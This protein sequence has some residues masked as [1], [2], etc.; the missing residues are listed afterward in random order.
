MELTITE[1]LLL[2]GILPQ[3]GNFVTLKIVRKLKEALSFTEEEIARFKLKVDD[4]EGT[5]KWDKTADVPT[6]IAIGESA[7]STIV[8]ALKKLDAEQ[9]L[10]A[11]QCEL[12][13][14]FVVSKEE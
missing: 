7:M 12:Y 8:S 11:Q 9:K 4:E 5:V 14:R 3:Q 6:E 10:L 13:E 1:R 2:S